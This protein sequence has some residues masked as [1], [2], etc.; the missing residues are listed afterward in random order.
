MNFG[1]I[2]EKISQQNI[3][4]RFVILALPLISCAPILVGSGAVMI[5]SMAY[6]EK[7]I[8]G[9]LDDTNLTFRI[10]KNLRK[11][12]IEWKTNLSQKIGICVQ[13]GEILLTGTVARQEEL[14]WAEQAVWEVFGVKSVINQVEVV[15]DSKKV[16]K[17]SVK[18]S[19]ITMQ[20]KSAI[21]THPQINVRGLNYVIKTVDQIVYVMGVSR[22]MEEQQI[23]LNTTARVKGVKKV[24]CL[25]RFKEQVLA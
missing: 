12:D 21:M 23:V 10:R 24:V 25:A 7:G 5:G 20:V 22:T 11:K 13:N 17:S 1:N 19:W 9:C 4:M 18:D 2:N 6:K 15:T 16:K 14:L 8:S 3:L